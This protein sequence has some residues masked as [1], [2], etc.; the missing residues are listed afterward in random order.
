MIPVARETAS[1][2]CVEIFLNASQVS[3][4]ALV[5]SRHIQSGLVDRAK[6]QDGV[7]PSPFPQFLIQP[8]KE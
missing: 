1:H 4:E 8:T 3:Q 5:F 7:V 2:I 6:Q